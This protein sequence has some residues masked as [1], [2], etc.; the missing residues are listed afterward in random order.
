[1]LGSK[2]GKSREWRTALEFKAE[3]LVNQKLDRK[4]KNPNAFYY[5]SGISETQRK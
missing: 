4:D 1:M 2:Q 5:L 3:I